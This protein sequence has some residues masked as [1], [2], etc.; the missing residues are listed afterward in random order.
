MKS[1]SNVFGDMSN[2]AATPIDS[3]NLKNLFQKQL[4]D[5]IKT[6]YVALGTEVLLKLFKLLPGVDLD[7]LYANVKFG[8]SGFYM[9]KMKIKY[10]FKVLQP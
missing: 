3:K 6:W 4:T 8:H 5:G 1:C 7:L 10:F 9:G 2:M